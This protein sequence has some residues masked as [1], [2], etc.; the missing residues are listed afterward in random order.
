LTPHDVP[1][2]KLIEKLATYLKENVDAV[3]PP[4]WAAFAKTGTHVEKQPQR[5]DWWYV[6]CA[7]VLRKIYVHGPMGIE[8]LRADYGG[9]KGFSVKPEH[10]RKASGAIIRKA[11][12]QLQAAGY[13]DTLK[14]RGRK[15]TPQGRKL[16]QELAEEIGRESAKEMPE[17][18]KYAKGD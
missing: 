5:P 4:A 3:T 1:A 17:L 13:V 2:P 7:S 8:K 9:N 18:A 6:R 11:L 10:A 16:L 14:T 12:Q 15:V